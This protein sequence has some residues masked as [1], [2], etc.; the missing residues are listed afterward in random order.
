[1][2]ATLLSFKK[3]DKHLNEIVKKLNNTFQKE[4]TQEEF[5]NTNSIQEKMQLINTLLVYFKFQHLQRTTFNY[6][7]YIYGNALDHFLLKSLTPLSLDE[8][9]E[10]LSF[11]LSFKTYIENLYSKCSEFNYNCEFVTDPSV[12]D[13]C[14]KSIEFHLN[15]TPLE[16]I[17]DRTDFFNEV[18]WI[19]DL[20]IGDA[21]NLFN[22]LDYQKNS[23]IKGILSHKTINKKKMNL[24]FLQ[25]ELNKFENTLDN[26]KKKADEELEY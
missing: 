9:K 1:M 4:I 25:I 7:R 26:Y 3:D 21:V 18:N 23:F 24:T 17:V 8:L 14:L 13:N 22:S 20:A 12:I 16:E 19:K 5:I 6:A 11:L 2:T 15:K 10:Y